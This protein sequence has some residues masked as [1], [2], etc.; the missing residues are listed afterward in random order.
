VSAPARLDWAK[1]NH[2]NNH[3]IRL[4]EPARLAKLVAK[5]LKSR[6]VHLKQGDDALILRAIPFV[7]DGAKTT[8]ELADAVMFV[9][10]TRP[11][12]IPDKVRGQLD[13]QMLGRIGRLRAALAAVGDWSFDPLAAALRAFADAEGVGMGKFG[14]QLRAIL[15]GSASAPDLAG[16]MTALGRDESL[17][18]IDDALSLPA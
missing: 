6:D 9:L 3:Y 4:A 15:A 18:R 13:E 1:L 11:M 8:L 5:I 17:G 14:P 16:T 2:L 10:K 7:R 12:D